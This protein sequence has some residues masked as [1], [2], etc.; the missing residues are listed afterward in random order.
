MI[1][2][3]VQFV[4]L[5]AQYLS[6]KPDIDEAIERVIKETSFIG[7]SEVKS[8]EEKFAAHMGIKNVIA[9]A[10]GTDSIEILLKA[11]GLKA[12][13]EV[14][15]PAISW[16][17]T[18]EA[19]SNI[20]ATPIFVDIEPEYFTINESLI[21]SKIT[22][23]TRAIIPV[24][25]YGQPANMPVIMQIAKKHGLYVLED[26]AQAHDAEIAGKKA[27][28]WGDCASFSF[29]PGKN[30]GA[31]GDAGCMATNDDELAQK[32]RMIGNH[33]QLKKHDHVMEGRNSR[34]DG[35]Q[36]AILSAKLPY[37]HS[38]TDARIAHAETYTRL[39]ANNGV[40]VPK[41]RPDTKHVF[42]L[43]VIR[44]NNRQNLMRKLSEEGI[45]TAI[46]YPTA[47]PFLAAYK[48]QGY[49]AQDFPVAHMIQDQILSLPMFAEL[50]K[51]EIAYVCDTINEAAF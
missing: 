26:C 11:L 37:L 5:Y 50:S 51:D 22:K 24:H 1:K 28:T 48:Q 2:T 17:S 21:E 30:L 45:Q 7:G 20:G 31:Y 34:L 18:S 14:L 40:V 8:F 43:Y 10:N 38:W 25:L 12:G 4:D 33:G 16:I 23:N 44:V 39:L 3:G 35:L 13:D 46:H 9:C 42:H 29:Y 15:V 41:T 6:I 27:G 47:L 19:V 49:S 36:A 32:C